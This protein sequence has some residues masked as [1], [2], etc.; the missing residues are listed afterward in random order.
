[1]FKRDV[2]LLLV[3]CLLAC[4]STEEKTR[5]TGKLHKPAMH[6]VI[7]QQMKFVPDTL[8]VQAGDTITWINR[9]IVDHNVTENKQ[10]GWTSGLLPVGATWKMAASSNAVYVCTIHPGMAG[11]ITVP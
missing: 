3:L 5:D 7:I 1:M 6:T 2:L 11:K 10:N 8:S 9:D 4:N